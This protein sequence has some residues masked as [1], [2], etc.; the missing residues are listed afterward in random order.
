MPESISSISKQH[1][2]R[3]EIQMFQRAGFYSCYVL[4]AAKHSE[5]KLC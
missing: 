2:E 5:P 4:F 3:L 1:V